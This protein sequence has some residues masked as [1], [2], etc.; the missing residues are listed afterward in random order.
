MQ[1]FFYLDINCKYSLN[2]GSVRIDSNF[3][4]AVLRSVE[5]DDV[6][7]RHGLKIPHLAVTTL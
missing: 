5:P 1:L 2:R 6:E 3:L 7:L 4:N